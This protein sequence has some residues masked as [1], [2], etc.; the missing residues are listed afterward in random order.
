MA[1][2]CLSAASSAFAQSGEWE[3][4]DLEAVSLYR[5]GNLDQAIET[6]ERALKA[7]QQAFGRENDKVA[8][9]MNNLGQFYAAK[10]RF[11]DAEQL[12]VQAVAIDEKLLGASHPQLAPMLNNLGE[13]YRTRSNT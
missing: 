1:G 6:E 13:A 4:L 7:A 8:L 11:A 2:V 3:K 5:Q 10:R 9:V 12:Y